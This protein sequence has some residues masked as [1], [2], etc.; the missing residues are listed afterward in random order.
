MTLNHGQGRSSASVIRRQ[1]RK[2]RAGFFMERCRLKM[3][4]VCHRGEYSGRK[5]ECVSTNA[6]VKAANDFSRIH[7]K[8]QATCSR[9]SHAACPVDSHCHAL[10]QCY[11]PTIEPLIC[12]R[13]SGASPRAFMSA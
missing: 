3:K 7:S 13:S 12:F 5:H 10:L 11:N 8:L 1:D 2:E 6:V 4:V 9:E